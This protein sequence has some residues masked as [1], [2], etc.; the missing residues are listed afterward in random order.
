[1]VKHLAATALVETKLFKRTSGVTDDQFKDIAV[2]VIG[3]AH[4]HKVKPVS[5]SFYSVPEEKTSSYVMTVDTLDPDVLSD[6]NLDIAFSL[7]ENDE[8]IGKNFSVWFEG[9][10]EESDCANI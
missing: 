10:Q 8:L 9:V 4:N 6:M 2:R 3:V 5:L 7:A 1:M